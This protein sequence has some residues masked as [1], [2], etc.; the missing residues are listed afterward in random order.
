MRPEKTDVV[1]PIGPAFSDRHPPRVAVCIPAHGASESLVRLLASLDHVNHPPERLQVV[2]A[3]DG[4]DRALEE[5]AAAHGATVAVLPVN[6]GSYA[7]RNA[8]VARCIDRA[9]L[10]LF[11]DADTEVDPWW[12][13][14]HCHAL[15]GADL[16]AGRID[17]VFSGSPTP[18]EV[19][20]A[21]RHLNQRL[22]VE[23]LGHGATANLAV[24]AGVLRDLRFDERLRSGGDRDF[25]N[26]AVAAGF[27]IVYT[28]GA[29]V[30]HPSRRSAGSVL[31]K[32]DRV[33]RGYADLRA[34]GRLEPPRVAF[35]RPS[36]L[37]V[38][39]RRWPDRSW[40]WKAQ[41]F[42]LDQLCNAVWVRRTPGR[43][44]PA[45]RRRTQAL[46]LESTGR[47]D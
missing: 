44:V 4:P 27:R 13:S 46:L 35:R 19:V 1:V 38:A 18:A 32:V 6:R 45:L 25:C 30:R 22:L 26:R 28:D 36:A 5:A 17:M 43:L 3:V 47:A 20:D 31:R 39:R 15:S 34:R 21:S 14:A 10:V 29:T 33:A 40:A 2:V 16:S 24:R 23:A 12:I 7:A 9:D 11:T 42:A 37:A 8:A 41:V